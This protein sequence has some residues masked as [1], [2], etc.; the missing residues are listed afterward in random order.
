MSCAVVAYGAISALGEGEAA[1]GVGTIG[2]IAPAAVARDPELVAAGLQRPFCARAKVPVPEG[3]DSATVLVERALS[4]CAA[5]LD[6]SLPGWRSK[7]IGL[8]IGTSSGGMRSFSERFAKDATLPAT[9]SVESTYLGPLIGA[10]RPC[11]FE[12]VAFVLG[13][14]ASGTLAIGLASE[15]IRSG[16]CEVA[17]CGGF[18]AVSVFVASGFEALRATC[19]EAGPRPFRTGRDGLALGEGAA[20]LALVAPDL[21]QSAGAPVLGYVRGFGATCDAAHL[22][23]PDRE[24]RGL[25]RAAKAALARAGEPTIDLV[26]AHGTATQFNDASEAAALATVLGDRARDVPLTAL[27][28]GIGHTLGAAGALEALSALSAMRASIAPASVGSGAVDGAVRVLD[29]AEKHGAKSALKLSAAFGGANGALVLTTERGAAESQRSR[30]VYVS[31]AVT[32]VEDIEALTAPSRLASI[33]GYA[34]DKIA[35]ADLLVRIT[36]AAVAKLR[37]AVGSIEEAGILVGLGLATV[38]TNATYLVRIEAAGA[39]RA[40]P[41]RFPFTTPNAPAGECA[42]AFGLTGPAFAVGGGPHGGIEAL[43]VAA[44]LVRSGVADRIVVVAADEGGAGSRRLAPGTRPGAV[45]LLVTAA[46]EIDRAKRGGVA[47]GDWARLDGWRVGLSKDLP[48]GGS[49]TLPEAV[50]AHRALLPLAGG[51]PEGL[52]VTT[53]WG[54]F[55][56][57]RFFWL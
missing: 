9:G 12:P 32:L 15:W 29:R 27:K 13:A 39:V 21:A 44:E 20:V 45:A 17:L 26:S 57:A 6:R 51:D 5:E 4:A 49:A 43:G 19:S 25:A 1:L 55:A 52:D 50:E 54:G 14:C 28:G 10:A 38:D 11:D 18:D 23:A 31:R 42:V 3:A 22:T 7:R 16:R 24:G 8:A 40:E 46:P 47:R 33:T 2:E 35:R 41:R 53:P 34:E 37:D 36:M 48:A 56:N 30:T